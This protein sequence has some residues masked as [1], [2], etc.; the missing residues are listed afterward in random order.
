MTHESAIA[1]RL[2]AAAERIPVDKDPGRLAGAGPGPTAAARRTRNGLGR[3]T[4]VAGVAVAVGAAAVTVAVGL[5]V[6]FGADASDVEVGPPG[7]APESVPVPPAPHV[8]SPPAWFGEPRAATAAGGL[9]SGRWVSTAIGRVSED[10]ARVSGDSVSEPIV[11]SAF[12]GSY[13]LLDHAETV[14]VDGVAFRSVRFGD[15]VALATDGAPT[16]MAAGQVDERTLATVLDAAEVTGP[17][18]E[19][20]LRL[21]SR[22]D[23]Y[24]EISAPRVL[25]PDTD[26]R[27]TL[28]SESG[29]TG[30]NEASDWVDPLLAAAATGSELAAVDVHGN[31]GWLG[32][33]T[34]GPSGP[35][36]F[37]VWSPRPG[38]VFEITTDDTGRPVGDLLDLARATSALDADA[39]D[40]RYDD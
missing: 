5:G 1:E 6:G 16:V 11:V 18:G 28:A 20:S 10:F 30:I 32:V 14:T 13:R 25:G 33:S 9:R 37:L 35:L 3:R 21:R 23:G 4:L 34:G 36:P 38:V 15:W 17:P 29:D 40:A 19:F 2:R 39:W 27:R 31:T 8:A 26:T 24:A 22:P 12:D 7:S